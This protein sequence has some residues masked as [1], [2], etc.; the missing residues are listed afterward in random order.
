V[1]ATDPATSRT[2]T[3]PVTALIT[4]DGD[5]NLVEITV[6]TDWA[7]GNATGTATGTDGHPFWVDDHGGWINA[8]NLRPGDGLRA[9]DGQTFKVVSARTYT[10]HRRAHNLTIDG[11][12]TYYVVAGD[13]PLLSHNC[14]A[15]V[16][17][18][19][20]KMPGRVLKARPGERS[21]QLARAHPDGDSLR[22]WYADLGSYEGCQR[23]EVHR[24]RPYG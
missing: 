12:H 4:G 2:E 6:D 7:R 9:P 18:G 22:R 11:I 5:K 14:P 3:R 13:T 1:Q 15:D 19:G 8:D 23:S 10:Q 16:G 17:G 24:R 20:R 21:R